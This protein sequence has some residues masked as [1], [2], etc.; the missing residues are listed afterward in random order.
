[1]KRS[2]TGVSTSP[3][4]SHMQMR[5]AVPTPTSQRCAHTMTPWPSH[6]PT[7]TRTRRARLFTYRGAIYKRLG[8]TDEALADLGLARTLATANYEIRDNLYNIACVHAIRGDRDAML[9]ALRELGQQG[10]S[11]SNVRT[12]LDDYFA[13]FRNDE[14][15]KALVGVKR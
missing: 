6:P 5:E 4:L 12:H 10:G 7:S 2:Q 11:F 3:V 15:F 8:R 1:M 14:E 9:Q 13:S